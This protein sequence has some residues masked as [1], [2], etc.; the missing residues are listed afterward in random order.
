M[1]RL[2]RSYTECSRIVHIQVYVIQMTEKFCQRSNMR[3]FFNSKTTFGRISTTYSRYKFSEEI[4]SKYKSYLVKNTQKITTLLRIVVYDNFPIRW[5]DI[6]PEFLNV[7]SKN[8][9]VEFYQLRIIKSRQTSTFSSFFNVVDELL[10]KKKSALS[11][12]R[13]NGSFQN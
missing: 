3:K 4:V 12:M 1:C 13:S 9:R 10:Y 7:S 6:I 11:T 8:E 2:K 5:F